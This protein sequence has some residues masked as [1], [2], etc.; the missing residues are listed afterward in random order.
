MKEQITYSEGEVI[1]I[2]RT[3]VGVS[4]FWKLLRIADLEK[5]RAIENYWGRGFTLYGHVELRFYW[6]K[7]IKNLNEADR[8]I[9]KV[10]EEGTNTVAEYR[11]LPS[12]M[13]EG[14]NE[15][16]SI[17]LDRIESL[18]DKLRRESSLNEGFPERYKSDI[19]EW[20]KDSKYPVQGKW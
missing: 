7:H 2:T 10:L 15:L 11:T 6:D 20:L 9:A 14:L 17:D 4:D 5:E 12:A 19:N 16:H 3:A 1:N 8:K 18:A 13:Q